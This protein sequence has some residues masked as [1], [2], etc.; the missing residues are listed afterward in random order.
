[1]PMKYNI[2]EISLKLTPNIA[3][4]FCALLLFFVLTHEG[5]DQTPCNQS[6]TAARAS[7]GPTSVVM[8]NLHTNSH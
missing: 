7:M 8:N 3:Q 1:M 2:C 4:Y 6:E 5:L